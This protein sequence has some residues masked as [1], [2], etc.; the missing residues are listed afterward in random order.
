M[1]ATRAISAALAAALLASVSASAQTDQSPPQGASQGGAPGVEWDK[2]RLDRL[3]RSVDRLENTIAHMK[4]DKAPPNLVEPD[5]EVIALEA[6]ADELNQRVT[7][8]QDAL[9]KVNGALDAANLEIDRSHKA[10]ADARGV[11]DALTTR[12]AQLESKLA[13]ME[14][15]QA[16][17]AAP[18]ANAAGGQLG[19][20][21][22]T[23]ATTGDSATDFHAAMQLV[24]NDNWSEAAK[25]FSDFVQ[26]WPNAPE[27]AE[28][29][30]WLAETYYRRDD[31]PNS[32]LEYAASIKDWPHSKWAPDATVKLAYAFSYLGRNKDACATLGEFDRRYGKAAGASVK[33]RAETLK[34]KAKCGRS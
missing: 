31:Q 14:Q 21:G 7:D 15:A 6:R 27:A 4:P 9:A 25:A 24:L 20:G 18:A 19:A 34:T 12:V 16:A 33:S 11:N 32:A 2:K 1:I 29:H 3:E 30:Y 28:A 22:P 8:M 26:R 13:A 5:P 10:E 23:G 17:A